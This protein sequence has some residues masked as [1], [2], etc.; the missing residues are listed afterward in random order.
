[1]ETRIVKLH[2]K[3]QVHFGAGRLSDSNLACDAGTL[4]SALYIESMKLGC[5]H[6]L[7]GAA[8]AGDLL[9][10]DAFPYEGETFYLPKPMIQFDASGTRRSQNDDQGSRARK[11]A[12]KLA[13]VP[14]DSFDTYLRGD[15]DPIRALEQF[16]VGVSAVQTKVNLRREEH[17][18]A[19]PYFVG[20]FSFL[21]HAG[22]YFIV[23]GS[24]DLSSVLDQLSLSG[25]GGKRTSGYGRFTYEMLDGEDYLPRIG[26]ASH[27]S[28][29]FMLLATAAPT[30]DELDE[31]LLEGARYR[32]VK[33]GGFVQSAS[34]ARSP[35]KK[36]DLYEFSSGSIFKHTFTGDVFDVHD[37]DGAHPV[38]RYARAMW[39]GV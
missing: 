7:L 21:P 23:Q 30:N 25:L 6:A 5:E 37:A 22:L 12:K 3:G 27:P 14:A 10:S 38:Y 1:M 16:H 20:G 28:T 19:M 18:D 33:R 34:Y 13:Y 35:Q 26:C 36:R 29:R 11:A 15:F 24:F 31:R 4:F 8:K 2:F 9:M 32:L 17:A 39:L